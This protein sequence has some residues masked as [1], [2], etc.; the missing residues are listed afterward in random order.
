MK[1]VRDIDEWPSGLEWAIAVINLLPDELTRRCGIEFNDSYDRLDV[2]KWA[3]LKASDKNIALVCYPRSPKPG[4]EI[5]TNLKST[6]VKADLLAALDYLKLSK[7][8]LSWIC[9]EGCNGNSTTV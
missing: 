7:D 6:D 3:L 1:S 5:W 9:P 8:D 4:T 2:M